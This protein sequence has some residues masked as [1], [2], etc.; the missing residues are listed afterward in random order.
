MRPWLLAAILAGCSSKI[1][2]LATGDSDQ[3][4]RHRPP[5][6]PASSPGGA[7]VLIIALDGV[8]R[9]LL[10]AMLRAGELPHLEELLGGDELAHAYLDD[11]VLSTLPS[12]TMAAWVSAM[13]GVTPA[14]HGV[15]GNEYFIRETRELA[16]PAPISF[17]DTDAVLSVYTDHY[18]DRLVQAPTVYER[19]RQREPDIQIWV[20]MNHLFRG[21]DHLLIAE[22]SEI[23]EAF[24]G[25]I[26]HAV[27]G[28]MKVT[29]TP[30]MYERLDA[31][32]LDTVVSHLA[33]DPLPD[34][35]TLYISGTD[36]YA[37]VAEEGPDRARREY[38]HLIDGKFG[39]I[40]EALRKR[41]R[42]DRE[43]VVVLADH[44]HTPVLPAHALGGEDGAPPAVLRH[45][46]F[47]LRPFQRHVTD[48]DPF[49]A[50]LAYGGPMA[51]VY[52][53]DRTSC[54]GPHD[55]CAWQ[56]PPRYGEDV[57]PAAEAFYRANR[58]GAY[59]ARMKDTLDLI[60]VR[61]PRPYPEVD[62]PFEVYVG[63]GQT[64]SIEDYLTEHPHP[65][66]VAVVERLHDLAVGIHGERAGDILLLAHDGDV[67]R[68]DQR[69]YFAHPYH[70]WHGSPSYRDSEVPLIVANRHHD[71]ASIGRWVR[72]R[73]GDRPYLERITDLLLGLRAGALG[74]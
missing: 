19:M 58:D 68:I 32:A 55:P 13:T 35:L 44:G 14:E 64:Q 50:V 2:A 46:G 10:Y 67:D 21:A 6:T 15:T 60:L 4:L 42:L 39:E 71:A 49:N 1:V 36:L 34:V 47:R 52:L 18:L 27:A 62:L 57:L 17:T 22:K 59:D 29:P 11:H 54:P 72:P 26:E 25:F 20:A 28:A 37:H 7:P 63:D 53:A 48:R 23:A 38:M 66:Y 5:G 56:Q 33:K 70:S 41:G 12:T 24:A 3:I 40:A 74:D 69:F 73:L 31:V 16:C 8:N 9:D 51:Y 30:T 61:H 43:W 45:A 65:T